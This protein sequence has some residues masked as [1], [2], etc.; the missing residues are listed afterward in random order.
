MEVAF[1]ATAMES[2]SESPHTLSHLSPIERDCRAHLDWGVGFCWLLRVGLGLS[3][4]GTVPCIVSCWQPP[5]AL[6]T[7]CQHCPLVVITKNVPRHCQMSPMAVTIP[8][9]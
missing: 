1:L 7:E 6:P 8:L 3:L 9:G 4:L 2:A 5:W